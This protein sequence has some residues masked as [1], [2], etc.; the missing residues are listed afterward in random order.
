MADQMAG[1]WVAF[2]RTGKPDHAGIPH[3]PPFNTQTRPVMEFNNVS[4]VV[5]DPL[6]EVRL[7]L[8]AMPGGG[9]RRR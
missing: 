8:E 9:P 4:R 5:D 1:A 2:A 6:K 7:A 3:W